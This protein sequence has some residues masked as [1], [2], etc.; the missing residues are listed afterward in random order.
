M[1]LKI[2]LPFGVFA[3]KTGVAR[4]VV[5][6]SSGSYGLLPNRLDCVAALVPGILTFETK[7]EGEVYIAVDEG[8][9]IKT[10]MEVLISVR[11]AIA[12]AELAT[13]H[14]TVMSAFLNLDT[15]ERD[16]RR[17]MAKMESGFI[18][19]LMEFHRER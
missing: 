17:M 9:L 3:E 8:I 18:R 19:R 14:E 12:G 4:I 15:Q 6:T 11:N 2:L 13:L 10:G 1:N 16:A 5:E 7:E